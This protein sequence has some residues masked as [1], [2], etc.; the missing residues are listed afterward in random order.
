MQPDDFRARKQYCTTEAGR[1]RLLSRG[2]HTK[3]MS[4]R[5]TLGIAAIAALGCA[6]GAFYWL[7]VRGSH[8]APE[9]V[10]AEQP[11]FHESLTAPDDKHVNVPVTA[12]PAPSDPKTPPLPADSVAPLRAGE[13]LEYTANVS[14]VSNVANLKLQ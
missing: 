12:L 10:S 5:T 11:G 13:V 14:K 1:P 6:A 2:H 9:V 8:P 7:H 4:H 3:E